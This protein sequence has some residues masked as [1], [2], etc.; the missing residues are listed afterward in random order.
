M[1]DVILHD[2][3]LS[4]SAYCHVVNTP[5]ANIDIAEW[6]FKLLEA[7]YQRCCP[8]D[9]VSC[10]FTPSDDGR[11]MFA[12]PTAEFMDFIVKH[13]IMFEEAAK[14]RQQDGDAHNRRETPLFAASIERKAMHRFHQTA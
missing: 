14:A 6:L 9:H 5:L 1:S 10:G 8:P 3:D 7:E 2:V 12:H 13:N 4:N 11:Q